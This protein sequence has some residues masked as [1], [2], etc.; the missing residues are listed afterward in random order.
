MESPSSIL[1]EK[2]M[3]IMQ[4][5]IERSVS[6]IKQELESQEHFKYNADYT[7]GVLSGCLR[8]LKMKG[9]LQSTHYGKYKLPQK[10]LC[11]TENKSEE[12][13]N[14]EKHHRKQTTVNEQILTQIKNN[15]LSGL[16]EQY[17]HLVQQM[18]EITLASLSSFSD[19]EDVKYLITL[20]NNLKDFLLENNI[21]YL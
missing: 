12:N 6:N 15:T 10:K 16:R 19:L 2:I 21:D 14:L 8:V 1:R 4:D 9:E 17:W 11:I 18:N 5:G 13:E 3:N 7:E 20:K